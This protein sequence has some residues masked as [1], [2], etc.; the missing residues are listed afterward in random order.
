M[1]TVR[2]STKHSLLDNPEFIIIHLI[3][4]NIELVREQFI[5]NNASYQKLGKNI[6]DALETFLKEQNIDFLTISWRIK[7]LASF[8]D[9]I[10]RKKY[11]NPFDEVEDICGVRIICYYQ[12]DIDKICKIIESEFDIQ[13]NQDKEEL[14][15]EDQFGYRSYHYVGKIRKKW[16]EAPNYRG[17]ESLKFELQVRTVLMHAWAEIEHKLAYKQKLHIPP[18]LKRKLYRISAKLE[19]ADEQFEDIKTES[20]KYRESLKEQGKA[21]GDDFYK[22][23]KF[24]LDSLQS[25][26]DFK[27]SSRHKDLQATRELF[28]ELSE[29]GIGF[30]E[31]IDGWRKTHTYLPQ[32]EEEVFTK[33]QLLAKS[34]GWAQVGVIRHI[35]DITDDTYF[36]SRSD[37]PEEIK[38]PKLAWRKKIRMP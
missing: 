8:I 21:E 11:D 30:T 17:L 16:L 26:L 13:E 23:A 35:L 36:N 37:F 9:K 7:D 27:F 38:A 34:N 24:N 1:G 25:Y 32:M 3:M 4:K 6:H 15:K 29:L 20:F 5:S 22:N 14:L 2:L 10:D 19:E 12:S 31:I 33:N 18:H 28:D